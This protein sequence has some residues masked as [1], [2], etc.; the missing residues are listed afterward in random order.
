MGEKSAQE[1]EK[2][3]PVFLGRKPEEW[4]KYFKKAWWLIV[5]DEDLMVVTA[6]G[7]KI[8]FSGIVLFEMSYRDCGK[9]GCRD[10]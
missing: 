6:D 2:D 10:C 7:D 8:N 5:S 9:R 3:K 1:A 4:R